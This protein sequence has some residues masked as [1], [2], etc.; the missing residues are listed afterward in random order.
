VRHHHLGGSHGELA[1]AMGVAR[2]TAQTRTEA[3]E[4]RDP[5]VWERWATALG[6]VAL[7]RL[8]D[9]TDIPAG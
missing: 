7:P 6:D 9:D 4:S 5:S 1:R 2:S 3:L 8:A